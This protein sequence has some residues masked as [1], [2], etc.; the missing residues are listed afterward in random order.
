MA[1]MYRHQHTRYGGVDHVIDAVE[2]QR[3]HVSMVWGTYVVRYP[4]TFSG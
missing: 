1:D 4:Q 3:E 2:D